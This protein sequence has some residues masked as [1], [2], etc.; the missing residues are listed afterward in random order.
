MHALFYCIRFLLYTLFYY[1]RFFY[2]IRLLYCMRF[3]IAYADC[4]RFPLLHMFYK[5]HC[6]KLYIASVSFL[7]LRLDIAS[8]A[9]AL[10]IA[11]FV[12]LAF[13]Y[14]A[15]CFL[16]YHLLGY[17]PF[18]AFFLF[19]AYAHLISAFS[20]HFQLTCILL[21]RFCL[22]SALFIAFIIACSRAHFCILNVMLTSLTLHYFGCHFSRI[23][24]PT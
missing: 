19:L 4:I 24:G 15:F 2:C 13:P 5:L 8:L 17:T 23:D 16:V 1:I 7:L 3:F 9:Y 6:N 11:F 22:A 18:I 14:L 10:F 20:N 21:D 12:I